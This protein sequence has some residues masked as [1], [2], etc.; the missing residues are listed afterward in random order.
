MTDNESFTLMGFL[1]SLNQTRFKFIDPLANKYIKESIETQPN[2]TYLLIH[3]AI[4]LEMALEVS[5]TKIKE[6]QMQ[7]NISS[8]DPLPQEFLNASMKD[9]SHN[10]EI[11]SGNSIPMQKK[12]EPFYLMWE[13]MSI[14]FLAKHQL[15]FWAILFIASGIMVYIKAHQ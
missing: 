9:W 5:N 10:L 4:T 2:A 3:R 13:E 14:R 1:R 12:E 11:K 6:L 8:S 15:K 7:L